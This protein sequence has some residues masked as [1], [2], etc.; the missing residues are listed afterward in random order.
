[1][2]NGA[3]CLASPRSHSASFLMQPKKMPIGQSDEGIFSTEV[4]SSKITV[5]WVK[6]RFS[7]NVYMRCMNIYVFL[8]IFILLFG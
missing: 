4:V 6:L 7:N 8:I 3:Y 2:E 1:M 5:A